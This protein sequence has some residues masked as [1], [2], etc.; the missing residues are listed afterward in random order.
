MGEAILLIELAMEMVK[1]E[2]EEDEDERRNVQYYQ[3]IR[4]LYAVGALV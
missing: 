3:G 2:K 4:C 1:K